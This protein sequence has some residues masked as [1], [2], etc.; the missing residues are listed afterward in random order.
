MNQNN[1]FNQLF[2]YARLECGRCAQRSCAH[3]ASLHIPNKFSVVQSCVAIFFAFSRDR[4]YFSSDVKLSKS[5]FSIPNSFTVF[6]LLRMKFMAA[7]AMV[8]WIILTPL[9]TDFNCFGKMVVL[10]FMHYAYIFSL[11][12]DHFEIY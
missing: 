10:L 3:P 9:S 8:L 12:I 1:R 2:I 11:N 5:Y 6:Q 4:P 7:I